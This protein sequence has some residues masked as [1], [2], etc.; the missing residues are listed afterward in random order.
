VPRRLNPLEAALRR[1]V[2]DLTSAGRRWAV[3]GGLAV[4]ARAEPRTTR[5]VDVVVAVS[6]DAEAEALVHRLQ[7]LGYRVLAVVEHEARHRLATARLSAPGEDAKGIVV[8]VLFASSGI[9][10][11][12]AAAAEEIEVVPDL[13]L[14]VASLGHLLALKVLAR[15]DRQRPQ[16]WDDIR[17]LLRE[18]T[19]HDLDG[20]RA[21]LRLITDRGY[22]RDKCLLDELDALVGETGVS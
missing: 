2:A 21:A 3:V 16:D 22:H 5:D 19:P 10:P 11:E 17:A 8:D 20:A 13:T 15:D 12:I 6:A 14:P 1:L 9:E 7:R 4:S 18:A